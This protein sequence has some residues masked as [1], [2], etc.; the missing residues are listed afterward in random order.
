MG[1]ANWQA[2]GASSYPWQINVTRPSDD[3]QLQITI[4]KLTVNE[5]IAAD[6][7]SL[8][9]PPG[10]DLLHLGD[11]T[12]DDVHKDSGPNNKEPQH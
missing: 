12:G 10:T 6:R 5:P 4:N 11:N 9:Q 2:T 8:P 3:Y 1:Y 7:F